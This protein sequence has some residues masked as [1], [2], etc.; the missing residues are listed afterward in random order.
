[1]R[2]K[3]I[4]SLLVCL[5]LLL[6]AGVMAFGVY[7]TNILL[8][9][10]SADSI[11][12]IRDFLMNDMEYS[13]AAAAGIIANMTAESALKTNV[14]GDNGTSY[15]LCQWHNERFD[16]LIDFA[17]NMKKPVEDIDVQLQ[18]FK[19]EME[20]KYKSVD[21]EIRKYTN[22]AR[23]ASDAAYAMCVLF[24]CPADAETKGVQRG[25]WA[26]SNYIYGSKA[27]MSSINTLK[28]LYM[29]NILAENRSFT[30]PPRSNRD[31][32]VELSCT[33]DFSDIETYMSYDANYWSS[34][35]AE[36]EMPSETGFESV[37]NA[38]EGYGW[39]TPETYDP[40]AW[41]GWE[42]LPEAEQ[43]TASDVSN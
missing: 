28:I 37:E 21:H 41:E 11:A 36:S 5:T 17:A 4:V 13:E 14:F 6:S 1:M 31:L 26:A 2:L 43:E 38:P 16:Q 3:R 24:E 9:Y 39:M 25:K 22:N 23:G 27:S 7:G 34:V 15:G 33:A 20:H 40:G 32:A 10:T 19:Y 12:I 35:A 30:A 8:E 42:T 29:L 18:F